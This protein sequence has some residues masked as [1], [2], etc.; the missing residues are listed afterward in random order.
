[1]IIDPSKANPT[2]VKHDHGKPRFEMLP[3]DALE[4]VALTMNSGCE[5]YGD[6]NWEKGMQ[7]GRVFGAM[8]RHAWAYW[9]GENLDKDSGLPHLAHAGACVLM[10]LAYQLREGKEVYADPVAKDNR[11]KIS[12]PPTSEKD[13]DAQQC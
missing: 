6:R 11:C 9:R 4:A 1:M 2:A 12:N 5:K 13:Y 8:M 3:P 10:L 7:Y